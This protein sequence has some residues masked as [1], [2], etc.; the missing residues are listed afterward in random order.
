MNGL[1]VLAIIVANPI[2]S[3]IVGFLLLCWALSAWHDFK[4]KANAWVDKINGH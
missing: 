1:V 3:T 2:I 4:E